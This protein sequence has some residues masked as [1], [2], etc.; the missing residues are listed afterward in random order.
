MPRRKMSGEPGRD[1]SQYGRAMT[2]ASVE[3]GR[4]QEYHSEYLVLAGAM[5]GFAEGVVCG[6]SVVLQSHVDGQE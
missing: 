6:T 3:I 4:P 2:I 1:P 5:G